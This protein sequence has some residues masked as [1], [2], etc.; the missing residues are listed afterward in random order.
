MEGLERHA[1]ELSPREPW[2]GFEQGVEVTE[3]VCSNDLGDL[4]G[5]CDCG[6][7]K[8]NESKT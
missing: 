2:K 6:P 5:G 7:V 3:F 1:N 8:G 4:L